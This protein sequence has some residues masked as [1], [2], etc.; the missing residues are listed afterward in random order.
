MMENSVV[1]DL[2]LILI[3]NNRVSIFS[4]I[5]YGEHCYYFQCYSWWR[6]VLL[7]FSVIAGSI[8]RQLIYALGWHEHIALSPGGCEMLCHLSARV[9]VGQCLPWAGVPSWHFSTCVTPTFT[10]IRL[11]S[12]VSTSVCLRYN[13]QGCATAYETRRVVYDDN[14]IYYS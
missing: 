10:L 5:L 7:T 9:F 8:V 13:W 1:K 14:L 2:S 6:I 12:Y 4:L 3:M 11:P